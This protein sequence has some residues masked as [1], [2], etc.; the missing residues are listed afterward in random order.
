MY[1]NKWCAT[2]PLLPNYWY[3]TSCSFRVIITSYVLVTKCNRGVPFLHNTFSSQIKQLINLLSL[4]GNFPSYL[5]NSYNP[6][7]THYGNN[8]AVMSNFDGLICILYMLHVI[9]SWVGHCYGRLDSTVKLATRWQTVG[10]RIS[11]CQYL[12]VRGA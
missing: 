9:Y 12:L 6:L 2:N 1:S 4:S 5:D 8:I 11:S 10:N 7:F 3:C